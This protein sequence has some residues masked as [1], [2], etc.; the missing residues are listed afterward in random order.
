VI[1]AVPN[2]GGSER[3]RI[4]R[5]RRARIAE[6][7]S[8]L[9]LFTSIPALDGPYYQELGH[10]SSQTQVSATLPDITR[11]I[12]SET[13]GKG[14]GGTSFTARRFENENRW[15]YSSI[16][17]DA[18]TINLVDIS[19]N[20]SSASITTASCTCDATREWIILRASICPQRNDAGLGC[21]VKVS[22][23]FWR[24]ESSSNTVSQSTKSITRVRDARIREEVT[25]LEQQLANGFNKIRAGSSTIQT[26]VMPQIPGP[27]FSQGNSWEPTKGSR[28]PDLAQPTANAP[29]S[30]SEEIA[31]LVHQ[32]DLGHL[33]E[34]EFQAAKAKVLGL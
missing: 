6:L 28:Q 26:T 30:V 25:A 9:R 34:R 21:I 11:L 24:H 16:N 18:G 32:R 4:D 23:S 3:R 22:G 10:A 12:A 5:A 2:N 17:E 29:L 15:F 31:R 13:F 20:G 33:S 27:S 8:E 1:D 7:Q 19:A 14:I